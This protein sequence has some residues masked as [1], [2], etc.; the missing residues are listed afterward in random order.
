MNLN[1]STI[2]DAVASNIELAAPVAALLVAWLLYGILGKRF[3][4]A[5]DD[6][7][8]RIRRAVI[9]RLDALADA[10]PGLYAEASSQPDEYAGHHVQ[11]LS[12]LDA[13]QDAIDPF[14]RDLEMA[15]Y[16]RNP[17]AAYK[18]SPNGLKSAGSWARRY[19]YVRGTGDAIRALSNYT[20]RGASFL[21]GA[22]GRFVQGLG[23]ILALRQ[24]HATVY[25]EDAGDDRV[26]IHAY[27]HDEP[28]S[29][30]P[31]TAA[32]HYHPNGA[33]KPRRGIQKFQDDLTAIGV[34][35][36]TPDTA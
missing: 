9:P 3:L 28:N 35:F 19:G 13:G 6:F 36:V 18:T 14:E 5:D 31:L 11:H 23:D 4:G 2:T 21:V 1:L 22:L 7:W 10:T 16:R 20:P 17:L 32:R 25:V 33:L 12:A 27:V 26:R 34:Q 30:N 8:P 24:V 15:G 29:L